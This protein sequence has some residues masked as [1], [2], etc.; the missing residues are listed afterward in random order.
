[1]A[2]LQL[3]ADRFAPFGAMAGQRGTSLRSLCTRV[4]D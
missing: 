4:T 1:V 3:V 2:E